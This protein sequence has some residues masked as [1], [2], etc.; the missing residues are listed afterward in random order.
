MSVILGLKCVG[1]SGWGFALVFV[2]GS[3][4]RVGV[5]GWVEGSHWCWWL[6]VCLLALSRSEGHK[7]FER[8]TLSHVI[9]FRTTTNQVL[10]SSTYVSPSDTVV[11]PRVVQIKCSDVADRMVRREGSR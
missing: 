1:V 8:V 10:A 3:R 2:V 6:W 5:C 11:K 9:A 7:V 4:P